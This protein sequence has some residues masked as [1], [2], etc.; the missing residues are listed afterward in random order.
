MASLN[1]VILI[2]RLGKD[3]EIVSF[4]NGSKKMSVT[5]ATSERYR[6]RNGEWVEQTDWHNLVS[7]G[8]IALDIA[9]KRRNYIKGDLMYVEGRLKTRQYVDNQNITRNITEVV[10]DKMMSMGSTRSA[11]SNQQAQG[12]TPTYQQPA[13]SYQQAAPSYQQPT[14]SY[15]QPAQNYQQPVTSYLQPDM[16]NPDYDGDDLPF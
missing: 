6:D 16:P 2:G 8:N 14:Q 1:K 13:Q 7:W 12:Q 9:E 3:P 11:V 4:D 10:V 5:L 15:Q